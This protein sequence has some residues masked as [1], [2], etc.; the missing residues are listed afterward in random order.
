MEKSTVELISK[1]KIQSERINQF[2]NDKSLLQKHFLE[3]KKKIELPVK[4]M[5]NM[6]EDFV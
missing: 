6:E 3:L 5:N 2:E 1:L 4:K